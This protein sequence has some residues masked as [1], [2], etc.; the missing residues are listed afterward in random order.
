MFLRLLLIILTAFGSFQVRL[1]HLRLKCCPGSAGHRLTTGETFKARCIYSC[2]W[3][4]LYIR[5]SCWVLENPYYT[6]QILKPYRNC[7]K[8]APPMF[9]SPRILPAAS[10]RSV[11]APCLRQKKARGMQVHMVSSPTSVTGWEQGISMCIPLCSGSLGVPK[12]DPT[13]ERC[14]KTS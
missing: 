5:V 11:F 7:K 12:K 2:T 10:V 8:R 14:N 13:V 9:G 6:P 1:A 3:V 4:V